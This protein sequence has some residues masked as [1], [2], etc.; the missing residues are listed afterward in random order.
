[1]SWTTLKEQ[2]VDG[3]ETQDVL[4]DA[5]A[6]QRRKAVQRPAVETPG[7]VMRQLE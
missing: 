5:A 6:R 2:R 7:E 3:C 4:E 1:M